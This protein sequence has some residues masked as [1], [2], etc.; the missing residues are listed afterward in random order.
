MSNTEPTSPAARTVVAVLYG[1]QNSEH[2][3]SCLSAAAVMSH[4]DPDRY[5]VV[6]VGI[7]ETG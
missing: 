6:T 5:E 4:L 3:I 7:T 1:G 2:S